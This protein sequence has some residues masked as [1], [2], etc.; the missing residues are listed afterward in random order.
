MKK[1]IT[2]ALT[3]LCI[4]LTVGCAKT[5]LTDKQ[6][7]TSQPEYDTGKI[8]AS[9]KAKD[10]AHIDAKEEESSMKEIELT[11]EESRLLCAIYSKEDKIKRGEL[12]SYQEECLSQ[13]RAAKAYLFEKYARDFYVF[14]YNPISRM[15]VYGR[16]L[17]ATEEDQT[18]YQLLLRQEDDTYHIED[19][20]YG[21]LIQKDYDSAV[22]ELIHDQMGID[23]HSLTSFSALKGMEFNGN[24]T[25]DDIFA[26]GSE[27]SRDTQLFFN[28]GDFSAGKE[29]EIKELLLN[30]NL[31][32]SYSLYY[33]ENLLSQKHVES[34]VR[35]SKDQ[36]SVLYFNC[37]EVD[38]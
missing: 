23:C 15:D 31:Y 19:N 33:G 18:S 9:D 8:K 2:L 28:Q 24:L 6:M 10:S 16:M 29:E 4:I 5:V 22:E 7:D 17:F 20:Y 25:S 26:L 14:S 37:F 11:A 3:L 35:E 13:I 36:I 38:H 1:K 27:L 30:Q 21:S 12:Y 34:Y 32:G